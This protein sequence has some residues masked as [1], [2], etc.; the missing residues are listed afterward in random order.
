MG[1]NCLMGTEFQFEKIFLKVREVLERDG[2]RE[3]TTKGMHLN[4]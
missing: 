1:I 4:N 3:Y 2:S